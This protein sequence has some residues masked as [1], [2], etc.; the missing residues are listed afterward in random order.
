MSWEFIDQILW[1]LTMLLVRHIPHKIN[2]VTKFHYSLS[3]IKPGQ[4]KSLI[5]FIG[6]YEGFNYS[7]FE[8]QRVEAKHR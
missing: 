4:I 8:G 6:S 3:D 7:I 5:I 1:L 2:N